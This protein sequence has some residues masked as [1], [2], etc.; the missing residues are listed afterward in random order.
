MSTTSGEHVVSKGLPNDNGSK[1]CPA[2]MQQEL[3]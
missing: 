3:S 2:G 1:I